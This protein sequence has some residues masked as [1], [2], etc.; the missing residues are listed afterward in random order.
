MV[1]SRR[2]TKIAKL[3][4][5][6]SPIFLILVFVFLSSIVIS[7]LTN[8]NL[9]PKLSTSCIVPPPY[10][11][12]INQ[13][14]TICTGSYN[15]GIGLS[16]NDTKIRCSP[17]TIFTGTNW[18]GSNGLT[19]S[20]ANNISVFGCS[21]IKFKENGAFIGNSTSYTSFIYLTN[22][23]FSNNKENG[24]YAKGKI[25]YIEINDSKIA[26]NGKDGLIFTSDYSEMF[27]F[28]IIIFNNNIASNKENGINFYAYNHTLDTSDKPILVKNNQIV[29]NYRNGIQNIGLYTGYYQSQIVYNKIN[30]NGHF[31]KGSGI[32]LS[33][34]PS[35]EVINDP[36]GLGSMARFDQIF[37]NDI[38]NN[39]LDGLSILIPAVSSLNVTRNFDSKV[40]EMFANY[41]GNNKRYGISMISEIGTRDISSLGVS[42][43]QNDVS[44]NTKGGVYYKGPN[45]LLNSSEIDLSLSCSDILSNGEGNSNG[46]E[47]NKVNTGTFSIYDENIIEKNKIGILVG[48]DTA[49]SSYPWIWR[50][51]IGFN[52]NGLILNTLYNDTI[53][54]QNNFENNTL[55]AYDVTFSSI[56]SNWWSDYSPNCVSSGPNGWC[57][58]PRPIPLS[59]Q[60]IRPKAAIPYNWSDRGYH[61]RN[62]DVGIIPKQ[63]C[64][65]FNLASF[66]NITFP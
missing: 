26:N 53:T 30:N 46:I 4:N 33:T 37:F 39:E 1:V 14:G 59:N 7:S 2:I 63:V 52:S 55:Q 40:L 62:N 34:T 56:T 3:K 29:N 19:I 13:S 35:E 22:N 42:I 32:L 6:T 25:V 10:P 48:R 8:P 38:I 47:I 54:E 31:K 49:Y 12:L 41:I 45:S 36:N 16:K 9:A 50:N 51:H 58:N 27:P 20:G 28:G 64:N 44:N 11:Q 66:P 57:Y 18:S 21:F 5:I 61:I 65:I 23:T 60:D 17:G 43:L 15:Y 24:I